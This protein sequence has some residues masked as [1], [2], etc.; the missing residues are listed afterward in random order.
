MITR[1][2]IRP[3]KLLAA[4]LYIGQVI[5]ADKYRIVK[6]LFLSDYEHLARYGRP[7]VGG[8][9]CAMANGPVQ[10]EALHLMDHVQQ[11]RTLNPLYWSLRVK[12]AF[13]MD[14]S[15]D[16]LLETLREP[17]LDE[18]SDS[19]LEVLNMVITDF[20]A[21]SFDELWNLTHSLPAYRLAAQREPESNNPDM[22]FEEFLSGNPSA[23]PESAQEFRE[24][25]ALAKV[26][27]ARAD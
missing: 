5:P 2:P 4:M 8:R 19:D 3:E 9:Y 18:L 14:R 24:N 20:G 23:T 7:I 10:S 16:A 21:K 13:S 11:G 27:P 12:D 25:Y 22:D 26:F 1:L 15:K 17:D 6:L